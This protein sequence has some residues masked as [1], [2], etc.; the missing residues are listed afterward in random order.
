MEKRRAWLGLCPR[1]EEATDR[2]ARAVSEEERLGRY[3]FGAKRYW[4]GAILAAGS[5]TFPSAFYSF[6]YFFLIFFS[7]F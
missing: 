6:S 3:P 2:W 1:E 7:V 4:A 5:N